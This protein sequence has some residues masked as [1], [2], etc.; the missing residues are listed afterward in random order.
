MTKTYRNGALGA[1]ID[2]YE[3]A[4]AELSQ[5]VRGLSDDDFVLVRD[6]QTTDDDCRSIQTIVNHVAR[7]AYG[8]AT[9]IREA[10]GEPSPRP[11]V[12]FGSRI[13]SVEQL[14]AAISYTVATFEGKWQ[15]TDEETSAIRIHATWG[16]V[17]DLEQML[18]H[19]IVHV[20][21][22]RRQIER[23]LVAP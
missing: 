20:L 21:R 23:F 2:E 12:Y 6:L 18:E 19:A 10:F 15:L 16:P 7:A 9:R 5:L 13:E 3:R 8:Y 14:S 1:L 11:E 4:A 22:H 17:Y